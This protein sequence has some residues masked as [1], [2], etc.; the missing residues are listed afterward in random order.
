M[1]GDGTGQTTGPIEYSEETEFGRVAGRSHVNAEGE[2]VIDVI[3]PDGVIVR[4]REGRDGVEWIQ[5]DQ[6]PKPRRWWKF[7]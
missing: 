7:W 4:R 2:G 3:L 6:K 1:N 5:P